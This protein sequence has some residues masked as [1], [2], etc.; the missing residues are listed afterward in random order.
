MSAGT[1]SLLFGAH[2]FVLHPLLVW[3]AWR[4]LYGRAGW[5]VAVAIVVHDWGYWGRSSIEGPDALA[6]SEVGAAIAGRLLG[7]EYADLVRWHSRGYA[8]ACGRQPSR[9]CWADK[10]AFVLEPRWLYLLRTRA[11]GELR[12]YRAK[13][14]AAGFC[15]AGVTDARWWDRLAAA[16]RA[17]AYQAIMP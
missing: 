10:M 17:E 14:D 13:S 4:R 7:Q 11:T 5:R 3:L 8:A 6:H 12:E 15:A 16:L 1:K 9:L 2:Q